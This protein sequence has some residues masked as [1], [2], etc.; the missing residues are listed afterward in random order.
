MLLFYT[1]ISCVSG[2]EAQSLPEGFSVGRNRLGASLPEAIRELGNPQHVQ[3]LPWLLEWVAEWPSEKIYFRG[4]YEGLRA[5]SV[6]SSLEKR[7]GDFA[8]GDNPS[9]VLAF[10]ET[11]KAKEIFEFEGVDF[12]KVIRSWVLAPDHDGNAQWTSLAFLYNPFGPLLCWSGV[13]P[14]PP[15]GSELR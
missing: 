12:K 1:S 14:Q 4:G 13:K 5:V 9:V 15:A 2:V 7:S 6:E 11:I 3:H 10:L 8:K